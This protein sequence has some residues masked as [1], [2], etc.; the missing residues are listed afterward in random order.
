MNEKRTTDKFEFAPQKEGMGAARGRACSY[1]TR[2]I[3]PEQTVARTVKTARDAAWRAR[4]MVT[5]SVGTGSVKQNWVGLPDVGVRF[6]RWRVL[7]RIIRLKPG[8]GWHAAPWLASLGGN[9]EI[10]TSAAKAG[11]TLRVLCRG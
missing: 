9:C 6:R 3:V 2:L 8:G 11:L 1:R 10:G 4:A 7:A 5:I